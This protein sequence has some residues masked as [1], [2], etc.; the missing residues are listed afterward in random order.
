MYKFKD[1]NM[2]GPQDV[3]LSESK[4]GKNLHLE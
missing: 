2:E 1:F 4:D 3:I